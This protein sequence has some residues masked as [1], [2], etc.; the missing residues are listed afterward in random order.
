M[1]NLV[2]QNNTGMYIK[3]SLPTNLFNTKDQP[4]KANMGQN[5]YTFDKNNKLM[6]FPEKTANY[7]D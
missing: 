4:E 3:L 6:Y 5:Q 1:V 7:L 2:I